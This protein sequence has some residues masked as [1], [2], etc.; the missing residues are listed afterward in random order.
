M[1]ASITSAIDAWMIRHALLPA[2]RVATLAGLIATFCC[3]CSPHDGEHEISRPEDYHVVA[4]LLAVLL[5][6]D[7]ATPG[8]HGPGGVL[9]TIERDVSAILAGSRAATTPW[10]RAVSELLDGVAG[11]SG[12]NIEIFTAALLDHWDAAQEEA[13][14]TAEE[15]P[16]WTARRDWLGDLLRLRPLLIGTEPYLRC[17]QTLL[18]CWPAAELVHALDAD[19]PAVRRAY[20]HTA[21][22]HALD[23]ARYA[24][25]CVRPRRSPALSELDALAVVATYLANDLGSRDRDQRA[26]GPGRDPNLVLLLERYFLGSA[27]ARAVPGSGRGAAARERAETM[28]VSMYNIGISRFRA[29]RTRALAMEHGAG[30]RQYV[31][32]LARIVDGNLLS[33]ISHAGQLTI[34]TSDRGQSA[35]PSGGHEA[36]PRYG[37]LTALN[38]LDWI[39]EE[40]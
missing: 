18:G 29:F 28:I 5:C 31:S 37:S 30:A 22:D 20:P 11:P 3:C 8:Q 7:D 27:D 25:A 15:Q 4:R 9:A 34:D 23:V 35:A 6:L 24:R 10:L 36:E 1:Q 12:R 14:A 26:G 40:P 38:R 16:A 32:L 33:T 21:L 19:A 17:W 13:L 39:R 2:E